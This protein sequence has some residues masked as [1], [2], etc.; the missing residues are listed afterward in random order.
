MQ[1]KKIKSKA[2]GKIITANSI[3]AAIIQGSTEVRDIRHPVLIPQKIM[4]GSRHVNI[5]TI[6]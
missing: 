5:L 2:S 6:I 3:Y 4:E 1:Q